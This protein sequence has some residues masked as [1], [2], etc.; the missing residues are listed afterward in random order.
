MISVVKNKLPVLQ[1]ANLGQ[2]PGVFHFSTTRVG[3]CS[4]NN[5]SSLNLGFNSG[6]LPENVLGNRVRLCA[7]LHVSPDQL[8]F[9]KQTHTANVKTVTTGFFDMVTEE[10]KH[11]LNETDAVI[12]NL[13]G[14]CIA[15][16]TADCV[17]ILLFDSK[18]KVV[19]AVH[20]GWRG[21]IQNIVLVTIH[22]MIK[23]FGTNPTDLIAGIGPSICPEVYEVGEEVWRQFA[24]K[25]YLASNSD[26]SGKKLLDLWSA[27]YQQ[28]IKAGIAA[29][30]IEVA[31]ICT[32]SDPDR[33]FS[34]RRD[35][36]K[37]GRMATAIMIR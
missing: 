10:Q 32:F 26:K 35:G 2:I 1:F 7:A 5:Y 27:N 8:V 36:I 11:F 28:L 21:T 31:R 17:P 14:V 25:F 23:E 24:P 22:K 9:P 16:K 29:E 19:A 20:A 13:Q 12:T 33:F 37:T 6:D 3:G 15:V 18:R 4:T 34:A 30:Q